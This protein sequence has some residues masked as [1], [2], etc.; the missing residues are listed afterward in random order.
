MGGA[1]ESCKALGS[2]GE[3]GKGAPATHLAAHFQ[4]LLA[5]GRRRRRGGKAWSPPDMLSRGAFFFSFSSSQDSQLR[6]AESRGD[7]GRGGLSSPPRKSLSCLLLLVA[8]AG[9][10]LDSGVKQ[11]SPCLCVCVNEGGFFSPSRYLASQAAALENVSAARPSEQGGVGC[12]R[13]ATCWQAGEF[14]EAPALP[15]AARGRLAATPHSPD[16]SVQ[17]GNMPAWLPG[18]WIPG[19]EKGSLVGT[20]DSWGRVCACVKRPFPPWFAS[21]KW[22]DEVPRFRVAHSNVFA[23][24]RPIVLRNQYIIINQAGVRRQG[25]WCLPSRPVPPR[26][27]FFPSSSPVRME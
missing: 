4:V 3:F 25:W 9:C 5:P 20:A 6:A 24:E 23:L 15:A 21:L 22:V 18:A 2:E 11:R 8:V 19:R 14:G 13:R 7:R 12:C 26:P 16:L 17:A 10:S 1:K 27:G